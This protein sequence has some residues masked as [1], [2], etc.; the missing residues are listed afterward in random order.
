M[1]GAFQPC[2]ASRTNSFLLDAVLKS[3]LLLWLQCLE[4]GE[5]DD[6]PCL[7]GGQ[8][9]G[10]GRGTGGGRDT[11]LPP[12]ALLHRKTFPCPTLLLR[13][14]KFS[15]PAGFS[16]CFRKKKSAYGYKFR[17]EGNKI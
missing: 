17:I 10:Q 1:S 12:W 11:D 4:L 3:S 7:W 13:A 2:T 14:Q 6:F 5:G 15:N 16:S 8:G 9:G